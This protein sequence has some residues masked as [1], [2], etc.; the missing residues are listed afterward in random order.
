MAGCLNLFT[1][2][3]FSCDTHSSDKVYNIQGFVYRH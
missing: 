1:D 3:A 2:N